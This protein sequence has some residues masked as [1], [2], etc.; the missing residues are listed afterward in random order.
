[1]VA[2]SSLRLLIL[3]AAVSIPA[4]AL[5][6][7]EIKALLDE[8]DRVVLVKPDEDRP[9]LLHFWATWC[10][11]C[12]E[13]LPLIA[14]LAERCDGGVRLFAVNV[15]EDWE[16]I[17]LFLSEHEVSLPTLRD[18]KGRTW[19]EIDGRGLPTNYVWTTE[20]ARVEPGP[21]PKTWWS[22]LAQ[23]LG[24]AGARREAAP[25]Q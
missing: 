6:E 21:H 13:E 15:G 20:G 14:E 8:Q 19:R 4:M 16:T 25:R 7:L 22:G 1:M 10:P 9:V 12:V 24:C 5:A 18:P 23:S 11:P 17:R 2:R 3:A